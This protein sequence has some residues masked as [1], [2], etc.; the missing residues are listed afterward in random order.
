VIFTNGDWISTYGW[1]KASEG[2]FN[3]F[4]DSNPAPQNWID[5]QNKRVSNA[6]NISLM[7]YKTDYFRKR[8]WITNPVIKE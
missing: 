5:S 1:F 7:V 8:D 6:F 3:N 4:D 2:I